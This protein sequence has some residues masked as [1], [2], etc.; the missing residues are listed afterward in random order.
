MN[1][2]TIKRLRKPSP[3]PR[4]NL[5]LHRSEY[6]DKL[7]KKFNID[8]Y[9][10]DS[11]NLINS[12][13]KFYKIKKKNITIGLGAEGIIKDIFL[14]NFLKKKEC[15]ILTSYP[16]FYMYNFYAKLF[17]FK[18]FTFPIIEEN[19]ESKNKDK[20]IKNI[21]K[22]KINFLILVNPSS[23]IEKKWK[24]KEI[25]EILNFCKNHSIRVLI[26]EV[27]NN[28]KEDSLVNLTKKYNNL[29]VLNSFSKNFGMPG[30]RVGF[31]VADKNISQELDTVRLAIELPAYSVNKATEI[32]KSYNTN[33][34]KKI[35]KINSARKFAIKQF[36]LLDLK[37][38]NHSINSITFFCKSEIEKK[39]LTFFL[40]KKKIFINSNLPN[41][42]MINVTTT[43]INNLK[44]FFKSL[45][46]FYKFTSK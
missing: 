36:N 19:N 21:I 43:N 4:Y 22:N 41:P 25:I 14:I 9:Y 13:S 35:N 11:N 29:I 20:I 33:I 2:L 32:I 16:N 31:C 37:T 38:I 24:K 40:L 12:L 17:N 26:D 42:V 44:I 8:S 3:D 27:Y 46:I 7:K 18:F 1:F 10:P 30:L 23:P 15:R 6:G 45:K 39:K 5:R 34:K 28:K